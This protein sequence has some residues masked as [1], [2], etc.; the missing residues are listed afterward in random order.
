V[1]GNPDH[2]GVLLVHGA[3]QSRSAW[4]SAAAA[5][6][7]A[8]RYVVSIDLRGHGS[9]DWA[10]QAEEYDLDSFVRDLREVAAQMP[11]RPAIVGAS[12]GGIAGLV[13]VGE[14]DVPLA[15]ALI[16]VDVALRLDATS[17]A[18]I[19]AFMSTHADG[20]TSVA[21]AQAQIALHMGTRIPPAA[22]MK[23]QH[24][25][26]KAD[27]GRFYWCW[28]P[29]IFA[30][31]RAVR[32][33]I[34]LP[35]LEAAAARV[36]I[37]TLLIRGSNN[38][39]ATREG[40]QHLQQLMPTAEAAVVEGY[41]HVIGTN[42]NDTFDVTILEFLERTFR[43]QDKRAPIEGFDKRTL[44]DALGCFCTGVTVV[45]TV[46]SENRP[47]GLTAN[48]FTAVSLEPPLVSVCIAQ[49]S[50]SLLAFERSESFVVNVLHIGQQALSGTFARPVAN[51]FE[52]VDWTAASLGAPAIKNCLAIFECRKHAMHD[53]GDHRILIGEVVRV[54]FDPP[55]DPLLFYQGRYRRVHLPH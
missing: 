11:S 28:D 3:G 40:F 41:S 18:T 30:S 22:L 15:R 7:S 55:R 14:S 13:A 54:A 9:S 36:S 4:D 16:L 24:A 53:A 19:R 45:T 23:T 1:G 21:E 35:R 10:V 51:R 42:L 46:N 49:T 26:R 20:F 34:D 39:V 31:S 37:P 17:A 29:K 48:S 25:L 6:V 38:E 33:L 32:S 5:L 44:R 50:E 47:I 43:R 2:P 27:N 12:L 8:G 52:G